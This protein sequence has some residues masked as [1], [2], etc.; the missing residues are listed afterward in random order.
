MSILIFVYLYN[1]ILLNLICLEFL[2]LSLLILLRN[3]IILNNSII[4]VLFYLV[5]VVCERVLGLSILIIL[6]RSYGNDRFKLLNL[7]K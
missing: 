6:I 5:F 7:S 2:I 1:Q 3:L 4:I